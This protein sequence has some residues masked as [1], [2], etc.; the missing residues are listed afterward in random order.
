MSEI[1]ISKIIGTDEGS[2]LQKRVDITGVAINIKSKSI[3][4]TY[5]VNLIGKDGQVVTSI[6]QRTY[7]RKNKPAEMGIRQK[8]GA[9]IGVTEEY[10]VSPASYKFDQLA[11]SQVGV[12]IKQM[13]LADLE[14]Y[15]NM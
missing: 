10:E 4:I 14:N 1:I 13:L 8:E 15:P 2:G 11:E 5:D 3:D 6:E 9:P 12:L 7:I